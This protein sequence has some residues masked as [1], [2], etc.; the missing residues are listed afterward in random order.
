MAEPTG[1]KGPG[2]FIKQ[3]L[4]RPVVVKLNSG[5]T[6]QGTR[7]SWSLNLRRNQ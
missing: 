5:V 3:L 4:G 1:S 6:Y 2:E 7:E